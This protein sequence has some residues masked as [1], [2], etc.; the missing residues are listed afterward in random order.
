L[1]EIEQKYHDIVDNATDLIQSVTPEGKIIYVNQA[2]MKTLGYSETDIAHLSLKDVIH[3]DSLSHCMVA[4]K[5]LLSGENIG[6]IE[7]V[8]ISKDGK[9]ISVEGN[10]NCRFINGKPAYTRGI[11]R[12]VTERKGAED[13]LKKSDERFRT[14]ADWTYD[15]EYWIDQ[16]K[17]VV[18]VSPSV[19]RITGFSAGEL[20]ADKGLI[21]RI[22]HPDDRALWEGHNQLHT[23]DKEGKKPLEVEFRINAKDE[24]GSPTGILPSG[25]WRKK[26]CGRAKKSI[27]R[28]LQ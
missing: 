21:D 27:I 24:E 11:F 17:D 8:F 26:C 20:I 16:N 6:T 3:T 5:R 23:Q 2:W 22:V 1:R 9:K 19:E 25:N 28:S 12:D 18:Y 13:N 10:V 4:F 15:M 7:A 14:M